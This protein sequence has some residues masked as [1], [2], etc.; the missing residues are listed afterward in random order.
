GPRHEIEAGRGRIARRSRPVV[1]LDRHRSNLGAGVNI[2]RTF[3][4]TNPEGRYE[5]ETTLAP[6]ARWLEARISTP[7]QSLTARDS[8]RICC[9]NATGAADKAWREASTGNLPPKR[10]LLDGYFNQKGA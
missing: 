2:S 4:R 9:M 5:R 8:P 10:R 3:L 1:R 6:G 7:F